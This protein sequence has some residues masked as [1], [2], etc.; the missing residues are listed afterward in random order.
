[1][2]ML[3]PPHSFTTVS[4]ASGQLVDFIS[5]FKGN[6]TQLENVFLE[7]IPTLEPS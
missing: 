4:E 2:E 3:F 7:V 1:M 6:Y 5:E